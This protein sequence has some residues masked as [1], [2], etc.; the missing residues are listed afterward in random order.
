[1]CG[2]K[3]GHQKDV[4]FEKIGLHTQILL[5]VLTSIIDIIGIGD[6]CDP[7][8]N[9]RIFTLMMYKIFI[10]VPQSMR[11]ITYEHNLKLTII[12]H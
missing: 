9:S 11:Q 3:R 2:S 10:A 12:S 6:L 1:M 4:C 5:I 8:M 7:L